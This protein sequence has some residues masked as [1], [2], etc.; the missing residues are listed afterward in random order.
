MP[1]SYN[2][3]DIAGTSHPGD[4][5]ANSPAAGTAPASSIDSPAKQVNK[6]YHV[7]SVH[8]ATDPQLGRPEDWC[9]YTIESGKSRIAGLH[10][11]SVAEVTEYAEECAR[12]FSSRSMAKSANSLTWSSRNKK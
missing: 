2:A 11:G 10:R 12:A 7:V 6:V 8:K 9:C 1:N 5:A 3:K 4:A